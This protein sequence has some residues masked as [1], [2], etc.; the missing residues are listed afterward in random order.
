MNNMG[1]LSSTHAFQPL[2]PLYVHI[3]SSKCPSFIHY[4]SLFHPFFIH[5][6]HSYVALEILWSTLCGGVGSM[7][8]KG[9]DEFGR[10]Y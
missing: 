8:N 6:S 9:L 7:C 1:P 3:S 4:I 2:H 5:F 10:N